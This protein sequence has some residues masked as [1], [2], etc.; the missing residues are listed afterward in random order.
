[1]PRVIS[2]LSGGN[3]RGTKDVYPHL[4]K[5]NAKKITLFGTPN[6]VSVGRPA[7]GSAGLPNT[8]R[9]IGGIRRCN[10]SGADSR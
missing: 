7:A 1:M 5:E 9:Y 2:A 6:N 10:D 8:Y 4:L 3:V